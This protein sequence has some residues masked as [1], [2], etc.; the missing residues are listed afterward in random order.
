M[1]RE[2]NN[3]YL[4]SFELK[5]TD[6]QKQ[7]AAVL[8]LQLVQIKHWKIQKIV[9]CIKTFSQLILFPF[10]GF[11]SVPNQIHKTYNTNNKAITNT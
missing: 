8:V 7:C 11:P 4:H 3:K 1:H 9:V 2:K 6:C 5:K 10:L